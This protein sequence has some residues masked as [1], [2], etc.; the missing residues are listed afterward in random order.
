[1]G[2]VLAVKHLDA[3]KTR[4]SASRGTSHGDAAAPSGEHRQL[5]LAM[6]L[7]TF[8][9]VRSAGLDP[10]VVVSP[11]DDVLGAVSAA[12]GRP[13]RETPRS[14]PSLNHAYAQGT[15]WIA[16]HDSGCERVLLVQAD[17]PAAQA[18]SIREVLG[19]A[20]GHQHVLVT[21]AGGDGTALL[22]RP[23]TDDRLPHFGVGSAAAHR[24]EGALELDPAHR[25]WPDLRTDVDTAADLDIALTI[26]VGR[27][28][29]VAL[30][31]DAAADPPS[32]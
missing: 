12:G 5:V 27:H 22:L 20:A 23:V 6:L 3:A 15:A 19:A 25:K 8:T 13:L 32:A 31:Y 2:A 1:M 14:A 29:R 17:L 24:H 16:A 18:R 10:I 30:G 21:D 4:L 28:T 7:D 9:A 26:G 11:D